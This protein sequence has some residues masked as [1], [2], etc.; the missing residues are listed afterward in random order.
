[1][2][3]GPVL[4]A[5]DWGTT[6]FRAALV[7]A[8]GA[9]LE[10]RAAAA[11]IMQVPDR[12]FAGV[13]RRELGGWLERHPGL[14]VYAG[15]MIGSRQ[16]WVEAPYVPCPAGLAEIAAAVIRHEGDGLA[17]HLVPGLSWV[18]A[19]GVPEV[20][21]G[22]ELQVMGAVGPE[23][24]GLVVLPGTHAKWVRVAGGRAL[25]FATFMTG[26][27][28]A[29]LKGHTILGRLM[30]GEAEDEEAFLRGVRRGAEEPALSHA[31][32]GARTLPLMGLLP[33]SGVASYL[34][35]LL[36]GAE[37]AGGMRAWPGVQEAV[38]IGEARLARLYGAA[39]RVLRLALRAGP[40]DAAFRGCLAV[41]RAKGD[42][43]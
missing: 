28:Y 4:I 37:I 43:A 40:E 41:A 22:E 1:M 10:R 13:A 2:V 6:S 42:V 39:G 5:I 27:L 31:L 26:E 8:D 3:N 17:V 25:G 33:E 23:A 14:P 7:A 30:Q 18:D 35:G 20:M 24:G 11:G 29:A 9:V 34:S 21:R 32:F 38:V 15:G 12:D 19:A 36:I 16:G